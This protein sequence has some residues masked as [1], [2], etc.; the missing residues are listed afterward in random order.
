M[1]TESAA[2]APVAEAEVLPPA[3]LRSLM[4]FLL[5]GLALYLCYLVLRPFFQVLLWAVVLAVLFEPLRARLA[6]RTGKPVLAAALTLAVVIVSVLLPVGLVA[7]LL[8]EEIGS[9]LSEAP[10]D[11]DRMLADPDVRLRAG[12]LYAQARERFPFL[13]KLDRPNLAKS[14]EEWGPGLVQGSLGV[15]GKVLQAAVRFVLIAFTLFFLF[16]DG[17]RLRDQ[18]RDLMPLSRRQADRVMTRTVEVLRAST[19]GVVVVAAIQGLLGGA[20]F[21]VLGIPSPVLWGVVM[22]F[23]AMIPMVGAGVIWLPAALLLLLAGK[24]VKALLLLAWGALVV[25]TIDNVLRPRLVGERSRLY[26][27][28]VFF[29]V[30]G[31]LRLFGLVGVLAGPAVFALA[32]TLLELARERNG[33]RERPTEAEAG[34]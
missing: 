22:T 31:G 30:L 5:A 8:A 18:L 4:L 32:A 2:A 10:A 28:V 16:R 24:T 1:S 6:L 9:F 34:G 33:R 15:L 20:M 13:D 11:I 25:G 21:A 26:E 12:E 29:G 23:F 14:L 3:R 7:V 17:A 19:Y 27:L